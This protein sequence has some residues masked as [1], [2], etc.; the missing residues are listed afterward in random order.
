MNSITKE[1][2]DGKKKSKYYYCLMKT[3]HVDGRAAFRGAAKSD[4]RLVIGL[5]KEHVGALA[6][7][8]D[9]RV[10]RCFVI[11]KGTFRVVSL[12]VSAFAYP[13]ISHSNNGFIL[14]L[15]GMHCSIIAVCSLLTLTV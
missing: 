2:I 1:T 13:C 3:Q 10:W 5:G 11:A 14:A 7:R 9:R 8:S 6:G 15:Q 4:F 12:Y